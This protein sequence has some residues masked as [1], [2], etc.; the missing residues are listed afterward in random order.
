MG[1][2]SKKTQ[3]PET[4]QDQPK[5]L[6]FQTALQIAHLIET[7]QTTSRAVT[8]YFLDRI[9][10]GSALN[11]FT[12]VF[13]EEALARADEADRALDE[14]R[15]LSPLHGVPVAIKDNIEVSGTP[16][17]AGSLSRLACV[18]SVTSAAVKRL[19]EAGMVIVGKTQ[20]TEFAFGLS[21][22]N[23]TRGTPRNPWDS[24]LHRAPGGSSSG[25]GVAVAAGLV[26]IAVGGDTG[27]SIRAPAALN[28][29]VGFK[30]SGGLI[31]AD[32]VVPLAPSLD[33]LGP[34][35]RTVDDTS[36]LTAILSSV[37]ADYELSAPAKSGHGLTSVGTKKVFV[38]DEGAFPAAMT[39]D[40]HRV[41][42]G[43]L[44]NLGDAGWELEEWSPGDG[45]GI[46]ELS[47]RNSLII[48]YEGYREHGHLAS[49]PAQPLWDV[50]RNRILAGGDISHEAYE[51]AVAQRTKAARALTQS[52]G[53]SGVLLMPVSGHGALPLD[54][55]DCRHASIGQFSRA[56][57]YL[58]FPAIALPAGFDDAGMPIGVQLLSPIRS[59]ARLLLLARAMAPSI[60]LEQRA[61]EL[62]FWGL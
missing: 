23:P 53:P 41:W 4:M 34:I 37:D 20:M 48:G 2:P 58:D 6:H 38:L 16:A 43:V 46:G 8:S 31:S 7:R 35:S 30:P 3:N 44:D 47:E 36:A 29:L 51:A 21:G 27:G 50:V 25:A 40:A 19:L 45:L 28:H 17:S 57:N 15:V 13:T 24:A 18:S 56:A 59:D 55:K 22:Q 60:R 62:G 39:A 12:E 49:D 42:R 52:I 32:G 26:P 14:G 9:A 10:R 11:A 54:D 1:Y 33:V 5:S 61:P